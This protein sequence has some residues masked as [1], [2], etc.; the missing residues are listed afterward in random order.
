MNHSCKI[1]TNHESSSLKL[2]NH[3]LR[4]MNIQFSN[5]S[6]GACSQRQEL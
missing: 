1:G 5:F 4:E 3:E 6:E 2:G